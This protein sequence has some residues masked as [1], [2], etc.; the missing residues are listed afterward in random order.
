[1]ADIVVSVAEFK[2]NLS[3]ILADGRLN[4][5][6]IVVTSRKHPIATVVP[7]VTDDVAGRSVGNGLA[8][9]AGTWS[10]LE[11]ISGAIDAAYRSR[12]QDAYREVP[13]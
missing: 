1:M 10:D 9:I 7:Y 2:A 12:D 13:V 3:R 11:Q 6:T 5:K 4:R 8:A